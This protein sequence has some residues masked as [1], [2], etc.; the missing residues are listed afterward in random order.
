MLQS[1]LIFL[2]YL[3]L[4]ERLSAVRSSLTDAMY[5]NHVAIEQVDKVTQVFSSTS[6]LAL[7]IFIAGIAATGVGYGL[8]R[9]M[10]MKRWPK[11]SP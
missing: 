3:V 2:V 8:L 6:S 1:T 7:W 10:I 11:P 9:S 4:T 5:R